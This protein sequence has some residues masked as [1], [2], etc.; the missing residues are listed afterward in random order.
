MIE[1]GEEFRLETGINPRHVGPAVRDDPKL[2]REMI[3]K[4]E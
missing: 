3:Y 4:Y 2:F 1:A